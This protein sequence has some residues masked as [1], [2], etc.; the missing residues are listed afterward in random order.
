MTHVCDDVQR[1]EQIF[2]SA[3]VVAFFSDRSPCSQALGKLQG[4]VS[5]YYLLSKPHR[6]VVNRSPV[7]PIEYMSCDTTPF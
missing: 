3:H 4:N 5:S 1:K 2:L 6:S 7:K